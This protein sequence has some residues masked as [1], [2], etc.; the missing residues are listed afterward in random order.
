MI[1]VLYL[2]RA[3]LGCS[4]ETARYWIAK[5]QAGQAHNWD[6]PSRGRPRLV[7][8]RYLNRL[9]EL[10]NH[11]PREYGYSFSRWTGEWLA[12][13]MAKELGITVSG[14]YIN[15]LLNSDLARI[16]INP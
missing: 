16:R 2:R 6:D 3:V 5:A 13:H 14:S 12:K 1:W 10:V 8:E 9:K 7:D 11:S 15:M 4:Q